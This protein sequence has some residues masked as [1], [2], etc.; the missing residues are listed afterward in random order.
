[1]PRLGKRLPALVGGLVFFLIFVTA[2][3]WSGLLV[4]GSSKASPGRIEAS[5]R[6]QDRKNTR[7]VPLGV[8][9]QVQLHERASSLKDIQNATLGVSPATVLLIM[10]MELT[11]A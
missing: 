2:L 8:F 10:I 1:M 4:H 7:Q 6:K 3:S 5:V 9:P 11:I